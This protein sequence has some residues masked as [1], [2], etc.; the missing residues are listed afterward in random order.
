MNTQTGIYEYAKQGMSRWADRNAIFFY[1]RS[2]T[3]RQLFQEIDAA[4]ERLA[5][6]GVG[7]G[8]VVTVHLP[9]CPQAIMAIYAIAKLGAVCNMVHALLPA[10]GLRKTMEF[11][12][13]SILITGSHF[14]DCERLDFPRCI[15]H[16]DLSAFMGRVYQ[17]GYRL[18]NH[19]RCPGN[20]IPFEVK[21]KTIIEL[22]KQKNLKDE[23]CLYMHS[24]GST[25]MPKTVMLSHAALNHGVEMT[26]RYFSGVDLTKHVCLSVLP[27]FHALGFQMDLHRV[28]S[29]GGT[30][31]MMSRWD[32]KKATQFIK[33]YKVTVMVGVP[34]MYRDLAERKAFSG[35]RVQQLRECFVGGERVGAE[36]KHKLDQKLNSE[37]TPCLLEGYGLTETASVCAVLGKGH[38]NIDACGYPMHGV[39]AMLRQEDGSLLE[40]GEG[41][42]VFGA[43]SL[44]MGYLKDPEETK[45]VFIEWNGERLIRTGDYGR[46]DNEG[47]IYFHD[48]IKNTIVR[49]GNNI[50]PVEVESVIRMENG[51]KEVCVIGLT[52]ETAGTEIV[53]ACVVAQPNTEEKTL[54]AALKRRC[55]AYLPMVAVPSRVVFLQE[56]PKNQMGKIDRRSLKQMICTKESD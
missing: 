20:S 55:E 12:E 51:V 29:C 25:G 4:A 50:F 14:P 45:R 54:T 33:K 56:L 42:L 17:I 38:Y 31:V 13:S 40:T 23:C 53:C 34:V 32:G 44:M 47:L 19:N 16:V 37:N 15:L 3:Y 36:L 1:G 28:L 43:K 39:T 5:A 7:R 10:E 30:L 18:K 49:K 46:I 24:S 8:T 2:L 9:N 21:Q 41:E 48:R 11:T 52:D 27:F 35:P 26:R 6:L 22:P